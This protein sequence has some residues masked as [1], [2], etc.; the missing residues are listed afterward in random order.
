MGR[1]SNSTGKTY[2]AL[3]DMSLR[4]YRLE[5]QAD[6]Q[7]NY[8][9]T[10]IMKWPAARVIGKAHADRTV[11]LAG[12]FGGRTCHLEIK[13]WEAK[14]KNTYRF[15]GGKSERRRQR[16]YE[17]ILRSAQFGALAYYLVCWRYGGNEEWRLHPVQWLNRVETGLLFIRADGIPVDD[18][19][20]WPDWLKAIGGTNG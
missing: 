1:K 9:E 10:Q 8:P 11:T 12:P 16:Q 3:V 6:Y 7:V 5:G 14:D 13:S 4:R 18:S 15:V 19:P 20:G 2:E 17:T